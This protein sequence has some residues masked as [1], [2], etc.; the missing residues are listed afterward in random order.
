MSEIL[1][2]GFK[3]PSNGDVNFWQDLEDNARRSDAHTH[4][5]INSSKLSASSIA[6]GTGVAPVTSWTEVSTDNYLQNVI[7]P[8]GFLFDETAIS[9]RDGVTGDPINLTIGKISNT[10][11]SL[12]TCDNSIS[13]SILYV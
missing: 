5:G 7:M 2:N 6:K 13:V 12:S 4:D 1:P 8:P 3:V 11:F 10:E 9:L